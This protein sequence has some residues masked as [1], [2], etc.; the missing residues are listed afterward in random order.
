MAIFVPLDRILIPLFKNVSFI[1]LKRVIQKILGMLAWNLAI[2]KITINKAY[3]SIENI[4]VNDLI[5]SIKPVYAVKVDLHSVHLN[6][7]NDLNV[8]KALNTR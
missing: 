5:K 4:M 8:N 6:Q 2:Y 1:F 3:I 7:K